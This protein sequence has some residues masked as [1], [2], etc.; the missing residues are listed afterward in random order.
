LKKPVQVAQEPKGK[1]RRKITKSYKKMLTVVTG[2][3]GINLVSFKG[4]PMKLAEV[5]QS[6]L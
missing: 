4:I 6:E 5:H 3:L 1:M 2:S